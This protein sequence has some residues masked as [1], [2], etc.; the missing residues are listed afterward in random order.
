MTGSSVSPN[1]P[2]LA[3]Q[4]EPYF[5]AQLNGFK[6]HGRRDPAGFE[7]MWGLSRSLTDEQIKG[8][9]AYYAGQTPVPQPSRAIAAGSRRARRSSTAA[10]RTRAFRPA[11][12]ATAPKARAT[13]RSRAC[14]PACRLPGQA[15]GGVPAH[16]RAAR[17]QHHEDGGARADASR[18]S[19]T[20]RPTCRHCP[21]SEQKRCSRP[22]S[23][24]GEDHSNGPKAPLPAVG[25]QLRPAWGTGELPS[26]VGL[27]LC[28]TGCLPSATSRLPTIRRPSR[29]SMRSCEPRRGRT[30]RSLCGAQEPRRRQAMTRLRTGQAIRL[31]SAHDGSYASLT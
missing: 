17:G 9:A 11:Q 15:V 22:E 4:I 31:P 24:R 13:R 3:G 14:R 19:R 29:S 26:G 18:T 20:W 2:N 7:Y 6:S 21:I 5:V 10:W 12:A 23:A 27:A 28:R 16:R 25:T 30:G 1:F 8:L